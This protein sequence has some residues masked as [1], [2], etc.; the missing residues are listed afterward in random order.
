MV[1][2][3]G[4]QS[5]PYLKKLVN[6][7]RFDEALEFSSKVLA[8][9][10]RIIK[11]VHQ[12]HALTPGPAS[13]KTLA[14]LQHAFRKTRKV[15]IGILFPRAAKANDLTKA[16]A[17]YQEMN[18]LTPE[19]PLAEAAVEERYFRGLAATAMWPLPL[20]RKFRHV[21][22]ID[23]LRS[24]LNLPGEVAECGCYRGLSSWTICQTLNEEGGG[25]DGTG[26][27]IFDSFAGLSAPVPEDGPHEGDA[28]DKRLDE[29]MLPG[30]FACTI[31]NVQRHLAAFPGIAYH[32]GWLPASLSDQPERTYR[33]IHLDVDLY[34]PTAGSLAYFYPRL[35]SGG[36]ILTDDYGWPG[37][38]RAFDEF[39]AG[40]S[41]AF[42][43][44]P[45]DQ[46]MLRK[47]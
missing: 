27:H 44:F 39:C 36:V 12:E 34:D 16:R 11:L 7:G 2:L 45:T 24:V 28:L 25:F 6:A 15:Q 4:P 5:G 43:T 8:E 13:E 37:A 38:R 20:G 31:E 33:F 3:L 9:L 23:Q 17:L 29:M 21:V 14:D 42:T 32:P 22:L 19:H 40:N 18:E 10:R 46:A 1:E 30:A 47:P 35:V 41:I 26:H